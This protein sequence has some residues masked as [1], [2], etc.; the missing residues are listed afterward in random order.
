MTKWNPNNYVATKYTISWS[1][2][3]L[4]GSL[5]LYLCSVDLLKYSLVPSYFQVQQ[6]ILLLFKSEYEKI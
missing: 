4:Q 2:N 1:L 3:I 5:K 6:A